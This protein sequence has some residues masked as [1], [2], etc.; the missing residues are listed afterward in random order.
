MYFV[1]DIMKQP[2]TY[3]FTI[4]LLALLGNLVRIV[5]PSKVGPAFYNLGGQFGVIKE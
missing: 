4:P 3:L 1:I 5:S 2:L